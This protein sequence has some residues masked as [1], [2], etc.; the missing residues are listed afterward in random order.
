MALGVG[1]DIFSI[2]ASSVP[3]RLDTYVAQPISGME[4][5]NDF[6]NLPFS[7]MPDCIRLHTQA[8]EPVAVSAPAPAHLHASS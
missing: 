6:S 3:P 7:A 4:M 1:E 8:R 2:V 5:I